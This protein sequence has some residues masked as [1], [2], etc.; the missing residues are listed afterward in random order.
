MVVIKAISK[1]VRE[2]II[3]YNLLLIFSCFAIEVSFSEESNTWIVPQKKL[4]S[5]YP[6]EKQNFSLVGTADNMQTRL[7]V[8]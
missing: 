6:S 2:Q 1:I 8:R 5:K 3:L 7:N 4:M